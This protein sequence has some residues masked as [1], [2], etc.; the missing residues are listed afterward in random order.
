MSLENIK[1]LSMNPHFYS[2]VMQSFL[3]GYESVCEIRLFFMA[4]PILLYSESRKK[5][6][7]ANSKSR[8]DSL[9]N[10]NI[11][12]DENVKISGKINLSGYINRYKKTLD[13]TKKTLIIL[14]SENKIVIKENKIFTLKKISYLDY[15]DNQR[16][17]LK[18]AHYLG[19]IF[20]KTDIDH[21]NYFLEVEKNEKLY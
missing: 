4:L 8:M 1:T 18:A 15:K 17:W 10:T 6:A 11:Q 19:I 7:S 3:S 5:L 20:S 9:F 13:I 21:L 14:H 16:E 12:L 2:K